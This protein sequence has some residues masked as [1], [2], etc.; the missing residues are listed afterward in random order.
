M[1]ILIYKSVC[2]IGSSSAVQTAI[3]KLC[4]KYSFEFTK[5]NDVHIRDNLYFSFVMIRIQ[6]QSASQPPVVQFLRLQADSYVRILNLM[7]MGIFAR[8]SDCNRSNWNAIGRPIS[9]KHNL[10][11]MRICLINSTD[12]N[13]EMLLKFQDSYKFFNKYYQYIGIRQK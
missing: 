1:Y 11:V 7:F 3:S 6:V 8:A 9:T 4:L 5:K 12:C 2:L 13:R 10:Y